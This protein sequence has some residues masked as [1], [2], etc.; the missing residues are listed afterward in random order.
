MRSLLVKKASNVLRNCGCLI[1][2][3]KITTRADM[4]RTKV[5]SLRFNRCITDGAIG[6]ERVLR[7]T[8]DF[9]I[10]RRRGLLKPTK[11]PNCEAD[12]HLESYWE[13][14]YEVVMLVEG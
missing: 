14:D 6:A 13:I 4:R 11:L 8:V 2:D 7:M 12:S 1:T 5:L 10:L 9:T 3:M